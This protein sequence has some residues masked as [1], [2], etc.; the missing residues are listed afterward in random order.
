M[1]KAWCGWFLLAVLSAG[2]QSAEMQAAEQ[3]RIRALENAWSQAV[4]GK[5]VKG[6]ALLLGEDLVYVDYDGTMMNKAGYLAS[7]GSPEVHF[8]HV[9]SDSMQ[10]QFFGQS[11]VVVGVYTERGSKKGKPYVHRERYIDTWVRRNGLWVCAASQ[12]TLILH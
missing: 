1:K 2:A 9:V 12:S 10:V 4:R 11:A 5:D 6:I 8:E 7:V 3:T